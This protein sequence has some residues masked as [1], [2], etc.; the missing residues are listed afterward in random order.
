MALDGSKFKLITGLP[1][2]GKSLMMATFVYPYLIAGYQ[3]YSNLWLNWKN[4][5]VL[6]EW[7]SEKNN[8]H[9]YQEI[10]DIVDV[11][12]CIVICDEIAE[13]LDPRNWENESG[14]IRRFFQQHRHHHVDVYGTT[15]NIT[16]VAKSARIVI[17]EWT[18][19]FRILRIIPGVIIFRERS[20]DRTQMLKEEPEPKDN[21]FFSWLSELRFFLKSKLLFTKW[22]KYKLELEHK[23]C[24]KCHDRHEFNLNICPKCKQA[25]V[26]KPTGIYDSCYDIKLRPKKHYWRPI[27]ICPDCGREHKSGYRGALSE[28]EF[29][30]QKELTIR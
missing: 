30:K 7:D 10:E 11:R 27:S 1:G 6:G 12:N 16:L 8:L 17:D 13:P 25:L 5:D 24:E 3:V 26:V 20:I 19:C 21:G 18:D 2:S 14:A 22:N 4:F 9:Y 29:L 28:E 23:F 15:Q